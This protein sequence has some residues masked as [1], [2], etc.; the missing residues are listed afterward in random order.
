[1]ILS[2]DKKLFL[3]LIIVVLYLH[4][5]SIW[6]PGK[7]IIENLDKY[8]YSYFVKILDVGRKFQQSTNFCSTSKY[9]LEFKIVN[10]DRG[11]AC[12]SWKVVSNSGVMV[13][14]RVPPP[15]NIQPVYSSIA[16][17]W[18]YGHCSYKE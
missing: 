6:N 16:L 7:Y 3:R 12:F 15:I 13:T 2:K 4:C 9:V 17:I 8:F 11:Q 5:L 1:M 14:I 18:T 10:V